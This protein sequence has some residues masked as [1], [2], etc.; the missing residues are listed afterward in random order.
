[1]RPISLGDMARHLAMQSRNT[2]LKSSISRLTQELSTGQTADVLG[3]TGGDYSRLTEIDHSFRVLDGYKIASDEATLFTNLAQSN[4][5]R[6]FDVSSGLANAVLII[7]TSPVGPAA[8]SVSTLAQQNLEEVI[9]HL[10]SS[11]TGRSLFG[12]TATDQPP[13]S[14]ATEIMGALTS[15]VAG[16]TTA[17]GVI[18][19]ADAWFADP[20]GFLSTAYNGSTSDLAPIRIGEND[21]I[22]ISVR[23]DNPAFQDL[24]R[25]IALTALAN[26]PVLALNSDDQIQLLNRTGQDMFRSQDDLVDLQSGLGIAQARIEESTVRHASEKTGLEYA[27]SALLSAD[28]YETAT[29]LENAQ[30]Q[31]ESLYAVTVRTSQLSLVNFLR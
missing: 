27:R 28:P 22:P 30:F 6:I 3:R 24:I 8:G 4:L 17:D 25:N 26:D 9:G 31:L 12:G 18:Q 5:E 10:N 21:N 15:A 13:M 11:A 1:M 29:R 20:G 16:Q 7:S 23:A 19:A 14:S 2:E